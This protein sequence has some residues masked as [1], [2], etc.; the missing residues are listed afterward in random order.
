MVVSNFDLDDSY[1]VDRLLAKL[2]VRMQEDGGYLK[3]RLLES[4]ERILRLKKR[5][6]ASDSHDEL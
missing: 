5:L 1:F 2:L 6:L 4:N 3:A